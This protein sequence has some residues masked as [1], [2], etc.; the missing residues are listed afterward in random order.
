MSENKNFGTIPVEPDGEYDV[1]IEF[2]GRK[3]DGSEGDGIAKI[4]GFTI[5]VPNTEIGDKV[6]IRVGRILP[7][8]AFAEVV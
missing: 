5:F 8:Y 1:E 6:R 3:K 2:K 7:H 4:D